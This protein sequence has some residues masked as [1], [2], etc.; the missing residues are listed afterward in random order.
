[1]LRRKL[2]GVLLLALALL[3]GTV[4][5]FGQGD[6]VCQ[7]NTANLTQNCTFS[8]G[9]NHWTPFVLNGNP[10]VSTID[11]NPACH[12]P[13]CPA[14]YFAA[15]EPFDAG[16]YQQVPATP[17]VNYLAQ[18]AWFVWNPT[19]DY[20]N[21]VMRKMGIDPTG[22]VDPAAPGVVWGPEVWQGIGNCP[23]RYC[24][25]L[26][27][28]ATA[29]NSVIT[30]FL[31]VRDT[32]PGRPVQMPGTDEFWVDD[33]GL[34]AVGGQPAPTATEPPPTDTPPPPTP[35]PS[36]EAT[37]A[38]VAGQA[39][40]AAEVQAETPSPEPTATDT[41][42]PTDTPTPTATAMATPTPLPTATATPLPTVTPRPTATPEPTPEPTPTPPVSLAGVLGAV[43]GTVICLGFAGLLTLGLTIAMFYYF[44]R[45]G[46][47]DID[48]AGAFEAAGDFEEG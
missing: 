42:L 33:V 8:D 35:T 34:I 2:P 13:L 25:G 20:D 26:S 43:S 30:V 4:R 17:G 47:E 21:V 1:M 23:N 19:G 46:S 6:D 15:G 7:Y 24:P 9:L 48:G 18:T 38:A 37:V 41:P 5:I 16:V 31:F 28:T 14:L 27:V 44:Y 32:F 22:G 39:A 45:V 11:G 36:P 40:A 3:L 12:S 10:A 29:Q